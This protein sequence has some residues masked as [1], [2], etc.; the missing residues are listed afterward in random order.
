MDRQFGVIEKLLLLKI[1]K[2]DSDRLLPAIWE[3]KPK[4]DPFQHVHYW[5]ITALELS[6]RL[7]LPDVDLFRLFQ[8]NA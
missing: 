3:M 1:A 7:I 2:R 5:Q 6:F 4:I 8:F